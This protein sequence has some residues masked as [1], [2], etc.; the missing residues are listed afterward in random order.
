VTRLPRWLPWLSVAAL[1]VLFLCH[2][3]FGPDI[4]Y[5]LYLG[6]RIARTLTVQPADNLILQQPGFI[7][8]YWIFQLAVR[9]AFALG[10][11][12][13]VSVFFMACWGTAFAFWLRTTGLPRAGASGAALALA[14]VVICQ[15]RYEQRPEVLSYAFLAMQIHWLATWRTGEPPRR[16]ELIRFALVEAIWANV[17]GYFAFGPILV[18]LR[19]VSLA[20]PNAEVSPGSRRGLWQLLALTA[21]AS[22][23]SPFGFRNWTEIA[24][25]ARVLRQLR[26][27]IQEALPTWAVPAQVW[28][29]DLFWCAWAALLAAAIWTA[30][31]AARKERFAL[32]LAGL[33][34]LLSAVAFRN[35]PLLVFLGAPL[36]AAVRPRILPGGISPPAV[37]WGVTALAVGLGGWVVSSGFYRSMGMPY[38]F[39]I[40]ESPASYPLGFA[41][42]L[43]ANGFAG[44]IFNRM[45]DGGY[46]EFHFP[47]LRIYGDSRLTDVT[48]VK[49]YLGALRQ[50]RRFHELQAECGFDGALLSITESHEVIAALWRERAWQPAYA[51]LHRVF[52]VNR[53]GSAGAQAIISEPAWY[54]G[55]DLALRQNELPAILWVALFAELDDRENLLRA[56]RQFSAAPRVPSAL[57]EI[58][59]HYGWRRSDAEIV[60]VATALQPREFQTRPLSS[61]TIDQLLE[62]R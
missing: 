49:R 43:R 32:L 44:S 54:R 38:G 40:S 23:A 13:A 42:Y 50:P 3:W 24:V 17:H 28:T 31:T 55:E 39:G 20:G 52:L 37:A 21:L 60:A 27:T 48:P 36:I 29:V 6:E 57:V 34:L 25:Y 14:A 18:V 51:D 33:G 9:G 11:I 5:H 26:F 8:L 12:G 7:N 53:F 30:L 1:L 61:A 62:K 41:D 35:I 58:A 45:A 10:G 46:L 56:L 4:W 16:W 47:E 15:T 22:V 2:Q 59:L 19:I